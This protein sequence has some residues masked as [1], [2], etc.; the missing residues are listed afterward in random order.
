ME[1]EKKILRTPLRIA[2]SLL[3]VGFICKILHFPNIANPL[4]ILSLCAIGTLYGLRFWKK[5]KKG[6]LEYNKLVLVTAWSL[7]GIFKILDLSHTDFFQ[8]IGSL[9][10]I[11]WII[12]EGTSY[13]I[14][15][16]DDN[17][18]DIA[19]FIWN[20]MMIIGILAIIIGSLTKILEWEYATPTLV[21]GFIL[22][23]AYVLKDI[24]IQKLQKKE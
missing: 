9:A 18:S 2:I 7:N 15:D 14:N 21:T 6:F 20:T 3:I 8:L 24:L 17:R 12:M 19:Y 22:V 13:L 4:I 11:V 23:T 16:K 10:F 1:T 5:S